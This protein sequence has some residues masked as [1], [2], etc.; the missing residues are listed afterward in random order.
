MA[1]QVVEEVAEAV[2]M[3]VQVVEE[4]AVVAV[5]TEVQVVEEVVLSNY[6]KLVS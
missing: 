6:P 1:K 5:R 3:E 2:R 4:V